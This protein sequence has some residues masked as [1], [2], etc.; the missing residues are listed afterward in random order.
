MTD[1]PRKDTK[2]PD[3]LEPVV[4]NAKDVSKYPGNEAGT[5][6][7]TTAVGKG[8]VGREKDERDHTR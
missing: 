5:V 7:P 8:D 4:P 3:D 2:S 1:A 6:Q